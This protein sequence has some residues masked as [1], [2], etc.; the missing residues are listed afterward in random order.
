MGRAFYLAMF[1]KELEAEA[2][3]EVEDDGT[4][5]D[6]I[7]AADDIGDQE[8]LWEL[9]GSDADSLSGSYNQIV[10]VPDDYDEVALQQHKRD[11]G[12]EDSHPATED[13][14]LTEPSFED[15]GPMGGGDPDRITSPD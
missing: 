15:G 2:L 1:G 12:T 7:E 9:I 10:R 6:V 3:L 11:D 13:A 8:Y 5:T 4:I 14:D